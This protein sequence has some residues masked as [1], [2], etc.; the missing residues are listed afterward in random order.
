MELILVII[1]LAIVWFFVTITGKQ[2]QHGS[3][4]G[5]NPW[6]VSGFRAIL[7]KYH[8]LTEVQQALREAG[9]EASNLIIGID[10]TKSNE[11][12]GQRTFGDCMHAIKGKKLNPYQQVIEI[13]G[14]T[15]EP[16]DEDKLIPVYGFGDI[17][18]HDK[19]VF[20]FFPD[21]PCYG[22]Q[23]VLERYNEITPNIQLSGPT[24]FAPLIYQA[25]NTVKERKEY[26]ILVII[27]DGQVTNE[28]ETIN[29]IVEASKYAL[30]I[31]VVG[32]GDGPW[33]KMKEFDDGLPRRT[34]D[35]FQFVN[36]HDIV[37]RVETHHDAEILFAT[38]ALQE[39]PDQYK[40]IKKLKYL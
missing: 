3:K 9:L 31:V 40:E 6:G 7:D 26:H 12:S 10:Y 1:V 27:A 36:F 23:E 37:K 16:F 33:E 24:N 14:K 28:Q 17:S 19:A 22:L 25:I 35:N 15:L 21:R 4:P 18:T 32:V 2:N 8:N 20:P 34:F 13:I 39:I 11:F 5:T 30:S 29:A 38:A